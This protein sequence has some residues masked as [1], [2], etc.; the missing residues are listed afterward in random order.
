MT[1]LNSSKDDRALAFLV[2]G[3]LDLTGLRFD[4]EGRLLT[5]QARR[6]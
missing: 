4:A 5:A 2:R 3:L 1:D 6:G